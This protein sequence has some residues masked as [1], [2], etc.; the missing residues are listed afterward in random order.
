MDDFFGTSGYVPVFADTTPVRSAPG[1]PLIIATYIYQIPCRM[2]MTT[3]RTEEF[4][5]P[6]TAWRRAIHRSDPYQLSRCQRDG[7]PSHSE[8]QIHSRLSSQSDRH[9][10]NELGLLRTEKFFK[11]GERFSFEFRTCLQLQPLFCH[12]LTQLMPRAGGPAQY[13][14]G[15]RWPLV[16]C[17][18]C[19]A[20]NV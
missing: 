8:L 17:R 12:R 4:V 20:R 5:Q 3:L 19:Q 16:L 6:R 1:K 13:W 2:A 9:Q 7:W 11:F 14:F 18:M 15:L 10:Y